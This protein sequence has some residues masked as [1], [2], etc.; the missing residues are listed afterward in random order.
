MGERIPIESTY[1]S[2]TNAY[3]T[4]TTS[5]VFCWPSTMTFDGTYVAVN[6]HETKEKKEEKKTM[7]IIK[8][9]KF[10]VITDDSVRFSTKGIAA[11]NSE[12]N[13]VVYDSPT[14][15]ITDVSVFAIKGNFLY[16]MPVAIKDVMI[17]D[18]I[19]HQEH[20]CY[21]VDGDESSLNVI[22]LC[23]GDLR[24]IYPTQSPFGFN[25]ITKVCS[26]INLDEASPDK[27]F[28]DIGMLLAM[29]EDPKDMLPY[30]LMQK[31]NSIDPIMLMLM[32]N[33]K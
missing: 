20:Y 18:V 1:G 11:K 29:G 7:N 5:G 17:T 19:V 9:P 22:D 26:F 21:V 31:Q 16:R 14:C 27:P 6:A 33:G 2:T 3:D 30:L 15:S 25:Y 4:I 8:T 12:G 10:G 23:T 24:T 32:C 13:Y 28:G